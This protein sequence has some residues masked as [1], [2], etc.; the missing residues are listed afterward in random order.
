M[1][2]RNLEFDPIK[3]YKCIKPIAEYLFEKGFSEIGNDN[4][5]VV[6]LNTKQLQ[7]ALKVMPFHLKFVAKLGGDSRER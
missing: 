1:F 5:M 6:F 7:A 2:I 4:G 3:H